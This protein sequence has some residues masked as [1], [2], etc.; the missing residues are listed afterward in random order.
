MKT[1]TQNQNTALIP[2]IEENNDLLKAPSHAL[3]TNVVLRNGK[4]A[5][6]IT[7]FN[8]IDFDFEEMKIGVDM[9]LNRQEQFRKN[10]RSIQTTLCRVE[11]GKLK[12]V[13]IYPKK[14]MG[15]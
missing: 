13:A 7:M 10:A 5:P 15:N 3:I 2:V 1:F 12:P 6:I 4:I 8:C 9:A 14:I 11:L